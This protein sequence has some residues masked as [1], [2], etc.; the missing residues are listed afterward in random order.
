MFC[1]LSSTTPPPRIAQKPVLVCVRVL[2]VVLQRDG[3]IALNARATERHFLWHV[4]ARAR[5]R[6]LG[7]THQQVLT[8]KPVCFCVMFLCL[9][10]Y[11]QENNLSVVVL[12]VPNGPTPC[13]RTGAAAIWI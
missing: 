8:Q 11:Q 1:P 13:Q 6:Q 10:E 4:H 5:R 9:E 12:C 7:F 2:C 3:A